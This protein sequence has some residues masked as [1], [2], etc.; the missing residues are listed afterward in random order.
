MARKKHEVV[1]PEQMKKP[2]Y[3]VGD[4][5]IVTFLGSPNEAEIIE[6]RR[7][8]ERWIYRAK[9]LHSG[10]IYVHV[11]YNGTEKFANIW[12]NQKEN[13]DSTNE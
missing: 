6:L 4:K 9:D 5:V 11:G 13:L 1:A 2:P 12:D 8:A 3:K 7:N 10:T